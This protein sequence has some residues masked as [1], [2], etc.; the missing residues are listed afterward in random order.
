MEMRRLG[1]TGVK[2]SPLCFGTMTFGTQWPFVGTTEL[3]AA[4]EIVA[5]CLEA[6][7]NFFDTADVY[8][9]G[10]AETVLGAALG[11]RRKDVILATKVRGRMGEGPNEVGLS[12]HH[13]LNS[14]DESLR[15]LDTDWIDLYQVHC[16]DEQTPLEETLRALD[17]LVRWGKVRYLGASNYAAWQ[18]MKALGIQE[19][20]QLARFV[21]LQ[22]LYNLLQRD[23]EIDLVAL[24]LDQ[25][26]GILPWSP[27][28]GGFLTGKYRRG[29]KR[30]QGAR[31]ANPE[32]QFLRFDE[33]QGFDVV[34]VL[35][36]IARPHGGTVAQA[37]LQWLL[38]KPGVT[39][40]IIG[41]R[42]LR[43]LDDNLG[44]LRWSMTPEEVARLDAMTP[45]PRI[46]PKWFIDIQHQNR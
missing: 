39:S 13:I 26:L 21:T 28:A 25:G 14:I 37:A 35:D 31:R 38:H 41:A 40:V 8:S 32:N 33:E 2:V 43:Q 9:S 30:P 12:R 24:C 4:Q 15:R 19:R 45:P 44:T 27:L 3:P 23:L 6:G 22:P 42:D 46:Y 17:D 29:G 5:R 1:T 18:L 34:E 36:A 16:W 7:I 11:N 20:Q 10:E